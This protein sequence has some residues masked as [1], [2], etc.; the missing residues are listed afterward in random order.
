MI[1]TNSNLLNC[2]LDRNWIIDEFETAWCCQTNHQFWPLSLFIYCILLSLLHLLSL[3]SGEPVW[4]YLNLEAVRFTEWESCWQNQTFWSKMKNREEVGNLRRQKKSKIRIEKPRELI[5]FRLSE[6]FPFS[7]S[8]LEVLWLLYSN[9]FLWLN[10]FSKNCLELLHRPNWLN[11]FANP[12]IRKLIERTC[13]IQKFSL[14]SVSRR[15]FE[16]IHF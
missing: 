1:P 10:S 3:A 9:S 6:S 12:R 4:S 11:A 16:M 5:F 8:C 15:T 7:S 14:A 2:C 13:S